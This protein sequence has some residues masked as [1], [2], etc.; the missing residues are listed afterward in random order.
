M[1]VFDTSNGSVK[2]LGNVNTSR[3]ARTVAV[4]PQTHA[5]WLAYSEGGKCFARKFATGN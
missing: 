5:V 1:T 2:M 3:G 4:D